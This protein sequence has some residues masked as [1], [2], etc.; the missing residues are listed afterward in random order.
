MLVYCV[1]NPFQVVSWRV[2]QPV[3]SARPG[4]PQAA[5]SAGRHKQRSVG[6][7]TLARLLATNR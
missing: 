2:S 6:R 1:A 5:A 4:G 3:A 7:T